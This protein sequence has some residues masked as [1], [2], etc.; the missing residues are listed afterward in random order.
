MYKSSRSLS[1]VFL[2]L[3]ALAACGNRKT[4]APTPTSTP[5]FVVS[6][7]ANATPTLTPFQPADWS[8]P[9]PDESVDVQP[10]PSGQSSSSSDLIPQ[11]AGQVSI[12]L[13]GSDQRPDQGDFRTDVMILVTLRPDHTVS[14][15]SFP[16]D[17][18]VYLPGLNSQRMNAAMEFGG[19]D[20]LSATMEYNFGVRPQHYIL[21]NFSGFQSIVDSL[22]GVD[23]SV[24]QTLSD[25]RTGYPNGF[26]VDS[27]QHHMNGEM[28]LWY[29]RSRYSTSDFDRL[30][31]AQEVMVAISQKIFSVYG[32]SHLSET[33]AAFRSAVITDLTLD[34][35]ISLLPLLEALDP[36][37]VNRF[38]I[39][40]DQ[41][42]PWIDPNS[43]SYYLLP[44]PD[45]IRE[46][47]QQ[48]IG[49]P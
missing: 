48:A 44:Q 30:R 32:L 14:L 26:T 9:A 20:M 27:G 21:T 1:L 37:R 10:P 40:T 43:G 24:A 22:G 39:T 46:M 31:R 47:L 28:A 2:L 12:V 33:Y 18:Y 5:I 42:T 15:V 29:V 11:P 8:A 4:V 34:D 38:A 35:A 17:L 3:L 25:A 23:V 36:N 13:L 19:F 16:R 45:A 41:A 7:P 6:V 49:A